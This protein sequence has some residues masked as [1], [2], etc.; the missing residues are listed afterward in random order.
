MVPNAEHISVVFPD[1]VSAVHLAVWCLGV[2][3]VTFIVGYKIG[4]YGIEGGPDA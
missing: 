2:L 3:V 4:K 1:I